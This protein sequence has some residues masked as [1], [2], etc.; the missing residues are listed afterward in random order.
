MSNPPLAKYFR[1][2]EIVTLRS[3]WND[4]K[5]TFIGFKGGDN[6]MNHGHLDLG[7][8]VMDASGERWAIDLGSDDYNLPGYFGSQRWDYYRLR[9]AGHNTLVINPDAKPDQDTK[10]T[11][12]IV[13]FS[14]R[15]GAAFAIADLSN[16]YA[17]NAKSV[18]RGLKLE[19]RNVLIQDEIHINK[20]ADV[21]WFF[22]TGAKVDCNGTTA[23]LTQGGKK[24]TATLLSPPGA[25][26]SVLPA[27]QMTTSP[28]PPRKQVKAISTSNPKKLSVHC[29]ASG[30]VRITVLLTPDDAPK[31]KTDILPLAKWR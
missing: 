3:A 19:G 5:A 24:L 28:Q 13:R 22:H 31:S 17:R 10:S 15:P 23:I 25:S 11:A 20:S 6:K 14:E 27:K 21:W 9:A 1:D 4:Q 7:S 8:F 29:L 2:K 16:A 18:Q 12:K 30:S 26:F